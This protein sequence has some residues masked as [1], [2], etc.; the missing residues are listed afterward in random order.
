[1]K[2]R[3]SETVNN[4]PSIRAA[5]KFDLTFGVIFVLFEIFLDDFLNFDENPWFF[6]I[7]F[8]II[9]KISP[10][11]RPNFCAARIDV[12][13]FRTSGPL[14]FTSDNFRIHSLWENYADGT[15]ER[16]RT[17]FRSSIFFVIKYY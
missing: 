9:M 2:V 6:T 12:S 4:H 11:P 14:I 17:L 13:F 10:K 8:P 15:G 1:M 16:F 7:G 3:G 5:Q